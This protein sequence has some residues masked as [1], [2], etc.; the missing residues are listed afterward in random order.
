M[1]PSEPPARAQRRTSGARVEASERIT[2]RAPGFET[3]GWT[4]NVGRGGVRV[5]LE[6]RIEHERDYELFFSDDA[7]GRR[8]QVAWAQEQADG[9]I[10]GLKYLDV[11][12]LPNPEGASSLPPPPSPGNTGG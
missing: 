1:P 7:N 5:V 8:V 3:Q 9:Q 4:L 12:P 10:V 6:D 2:L 11:E